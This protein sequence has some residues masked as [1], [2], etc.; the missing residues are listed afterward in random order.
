MNLGDCPGLSGLLYLE[1]IALLVFDGLY[2]RN[3]YLPRPSALFLGCV[4]QWYSN[5]LVLR[6]ASF[7]L[8]NLPPPHMGGGRIYYNKFSQSVK[9]LISSMLLFSDIDTP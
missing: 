7:L 1:R 2:P 3:I 8:S 4:L 5:D 6:Q 9:I